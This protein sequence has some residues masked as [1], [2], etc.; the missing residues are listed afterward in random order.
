MSPSKNPYKDPWWE[1]VVADGVPP[2]PGSHGVSDADTFDVIV[3]GA[4]AGGYV[5]AIVAAQGGASVLILEAAA[6][7]GGT[8]YKSGAG[9]WVPDN[10]LMLARGRGPNRDWAIHHMARLAFPKVYDADAPN[11]GLEQRDYDLIETY[12]EHA[13]TALD[14]LRDLGFPLMEFPSF[15]GN[16]EAMVEY[17]SDTENGFGAH[18]APMKDTGEYGAGVHMVARLEAMAVARG[19]EMRTEHRV[20][21]VI[22][23]ADGAVIGVTAT[24]PGGDVELHARRGVVFATGGYPHNRELAA[25]NFPGGLYGSCAVPTARGDFIAIATEL[26]AEL[27]NMGEG[28]GTEHPLEQMVRDGEVAEHNGT[29][30]GDS[31]LMVNGAGKR[32]VNEKMTYHERSKIHFVRDEDGGLPNHLMFIVFDRFIVEDETSQPNKW[33]DPNPSNYWVISG[34]TLDD[35]AAQIAARLEGLSEATGG[36]TLKPE[37]AANLKATVERFHAFARNGVD[38]DFHRGETDIELDWTG[39]SHVEN[40]KNPTMWPLDDGPYYAIIM[41]G[42]VLDTN[43]GPRASAAGEILRADGSVIPGL[44]GVGNCVA[45]VAGAGYWSGGS[46]LGPI[47]T[48]ATLT[49]KHLAAQPARE[50]QA[51]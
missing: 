43:G 8:T 33:P 46:T 50:L 17:H 48:F 29:Y 10:S 12:Y 22:Q 42:S 20:T 39:P 26:G 34:E 28:W 31:V 1:R 51:S 13:A 15:T 18:L 4:G 11:L 41:A 3:A 9:M 5:T 35:L 21:G 2:R 44:Y 24:T 16:Y 47:V 27:G 14:E 30:P 36:Y 23:D 38:E 49:G 25:E 37:F 45:S 7:G 32:V 40:D 19:V 6:E